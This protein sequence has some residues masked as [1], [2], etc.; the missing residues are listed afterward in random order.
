MGAIMATTM[1][2]RHSLIGDEIDYGLL[3]G[4]TKP[5]AV[6]IDPHTHDM[7]PPAPTDLRKAIEIA[8]RKRDLVEEVGKAAAAAE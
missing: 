5:A 3:L 4:F 8:R 1:E 7:A 2:K 6:R